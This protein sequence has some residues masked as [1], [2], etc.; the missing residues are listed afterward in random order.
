MSQYIISCSCLGCLIHKGLEVDLHQRVP[1]KSNFK[2]SYWLNHCLDE[3]YITNMQLY[4]IHMTLKGIINCNNHKALC[5]A[6][7]T[8]TFCISPRS[9]KVIVQLL[10]KTNNNF[11]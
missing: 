11:R 4:I 8:V 9:I 1:Q 7:L 6:I 5:M 3:L 2:V 10:T